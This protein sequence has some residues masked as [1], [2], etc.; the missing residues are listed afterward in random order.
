MVRSTFAEV[1]GLV[2]IFLDT[3]FITGLIDSRPLGQVIFW[4][5]LFIVASSCYV[6]ALQ[7]WRKRKPRDPLSHS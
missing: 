3:W 1:L 6:A 2:L 5:P 7:H 4:L